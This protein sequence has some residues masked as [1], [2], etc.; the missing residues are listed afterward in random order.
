MFHKANANSSN[1]L[2]FLFTLTFGSTFKFGVHPNF[3]MLSPFLSAAK[4]NV[5]ACSTKQLATYLIYVVNFY[6]IKGPEK[7][8]YNVNRSSIAAFNFSTHVLQLFPFISIWN[9]NIVGVSYFI[10]N[11]FHQKK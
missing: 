7:S 8:D 5:T 1:T 3:P 11:Y 6:I 9:H 2:W 10:S 4:T